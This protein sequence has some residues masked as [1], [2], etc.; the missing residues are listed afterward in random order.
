MSSNNDFPNSA[1]YISHISVSERPVDPWATSSG[2]ISRPLFLEQKRY[3]FAT[4]TLSI[5]Q[6]ATAIDDY[7]IISHHYLKFT[8]IFRIRVLASKPNEPGAASRS[9]SSSITGPNPPSQPER[10]YR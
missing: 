3:N 4:D 2:A 1:S 10:S 8:P 7:E 9:A 6:H 5:N